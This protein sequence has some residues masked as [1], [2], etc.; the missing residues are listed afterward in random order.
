MRARRMRLEQAP[1]ADR[2]WLRTVLDQISRDFGPRVELRPDGMLALRLTGDSK[3]STVMSATSYCSGHLQTTAAALLRVH[4]PADRTGRIRLA[5]RAEAVPGPSAAGG[6]TRPP[7]SRTR[8]AAQSHAIMADV[9]EVEVVAHDE[10]AT[11]RCGYVFLKIDADQTRTDV[12]IEAMA[13]APIP[14]PEVL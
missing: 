10:R 3:D 14:T 12:E 5:R 6:G 2:Q 8:S 1:A 9:E 4:A 13:M 11:L 7:G